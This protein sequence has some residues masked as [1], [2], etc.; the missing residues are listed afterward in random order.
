[1]KKYAEEEGIMCQPRKMLISSSTLEKGTLITPLLLFYLHLGLFVTDIRRFVEL[2]P[3]KCFNSFVQLAVD[4]KKLKA[5]YP[6][7]GVVAETMKLLADSSYGYH[8][9]DRSRHTVKK[10]LSDKKKTHPAN[11]SKLILWTIH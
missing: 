6:N 3:K 11:N 2:T 4:A 8:I 9:M 7:S 1:M 10:Y 5:K